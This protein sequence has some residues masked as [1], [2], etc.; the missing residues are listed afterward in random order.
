LG[1]AGLNEIF[2]E[3]THLG[4]DEDELLRMME[5]SEIKRVEEF[6]SRRKALG[7]MKPRDLLAEDLMEFW[8]PNK[9][10]RLE[11]RWSDDAAVARIWI[12]PDDWM[13]IAEGERVDLEGNRYNYEGAAYFTCWKFNCRKRGEVLVAYASTKNPETGGEG[14]EGGIKSLVQSRA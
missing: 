10:V 12:D 1:P 13:H 4:A 11:A 8:R 3:L 9:A 2:D 14:Y 7:T 5:A 6:V